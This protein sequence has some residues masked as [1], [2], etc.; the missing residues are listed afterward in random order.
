MKKR[1]LNVLPIIAFS[2]VCLA[3]YTT[4]NTANAECTLTQ[5]AGVDGS[6][7]YS[8][9]TGFFCGEKTQRVEC[10]KEKPTITH[11]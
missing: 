9:P 4:M 6:C 3:S 7:W 11:S 10:I 8:E 5:K 2:L 1:I